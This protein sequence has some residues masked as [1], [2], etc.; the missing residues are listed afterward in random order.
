MMALS[1]ITIIG[2]GL[3]LGTGTYYVNGAKTMQAGQVDHHYGHMPAN[4][5]QIDFR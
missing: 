3:I 5:H 2:I 4:L 1:I